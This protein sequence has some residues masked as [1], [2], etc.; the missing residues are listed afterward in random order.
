M[1]SYQCVVE[2]DGLPPLRWVFNYKTNSFVLALRLALRDAWTCSG[3]VVSVV[4]VVQHD[5]FI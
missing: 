1:R 3:R 5:C 2:D 4:E